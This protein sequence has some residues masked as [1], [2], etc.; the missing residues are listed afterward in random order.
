M[1]AMWMEMTQLFEFLQR[2][3]ATVNKFLQKGTPKIPSI[4]EVY[5][6]GVRTNLRVYE[7]EAFYLVISPEKAFVKKGTSAVDLNLEATEAFWLGVFKGEHSLISGL[8]TGKMKVRG[9]RSSL[10]PLVLL[11]SLISLFSNIQ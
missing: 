6:L 3:V 10:V 9:L 1:R 2:F 7:G 11:S 5:P 4:P 8:P